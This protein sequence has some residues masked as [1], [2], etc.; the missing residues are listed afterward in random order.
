MGYIHCKHRRLACPEPFNIAQGRLIEGLGRALSNPN[1]KFILEASK[2]L[3]SFLL[4]IIRAVM[5]NCEKLLFPSDA[6]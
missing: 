4:D 1:C 5:I 2:I 3:K 6:E